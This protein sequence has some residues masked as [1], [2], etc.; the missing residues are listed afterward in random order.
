RGN[1]VDAPGLNYLGLGRARNFVIDNFFGFFALI[2]SGPALGLWPPARQF[3]ASRY[4]AFFVVVGGPLLFAS[5]ARAQDAAIRI[6]L[7][8]SLSNA[9]DVEICIDLHARVTRADHR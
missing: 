3:C 7:I 1:T 6:E 8:R 9:I 4:S 2:A 5:L